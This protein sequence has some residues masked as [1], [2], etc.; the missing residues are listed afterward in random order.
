MRI[1]HP[2]RVAGIS[3]GVLVLALIALVIRPVVSAI[4]VRNSIVGMS[5][6][7]FDT[8]EL[9]RWAKRHRATVTCQD[10][11]CDADVALSNG[12]LH[13]LG[14][15]PLTLLVAHVAIVRGQLAETSFMLSDVRYSHGRHAGA[16]TLLAM[17]YEPSETARSS[18]GR[19]FVG[20]GPTGKPPFVSYTVTPQSGPR[21]IAIAR[22]INVWCL[23]RLG[24]CAAQQHAPEVWSMPSTL[25]QIPNLGA[26]WRPRG[27]SFA[28]EQSPS[29]P[30]R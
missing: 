12:I 10:D 15:A 27:G 14:L 13:R 19:A 21:A 3:G 22:A 9:R 28:S 18:V 29:T 16:C 23:A 8:A 30:S 2:Y 6:G 20:H 26:N 7:R 17:E 1:P 5:Q 25:P 11:R 4:A 24:G